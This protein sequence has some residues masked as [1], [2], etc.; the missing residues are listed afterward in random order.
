MVIYREP[1]G[2]VW[3]VVNRRVEFLPPD[4]PIVYGW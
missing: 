4:P 1:G 2:R 3:E